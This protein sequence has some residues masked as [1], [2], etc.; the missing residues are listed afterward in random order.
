VTC[1]K[2]LRRGDVISGMIRPL[3][4]LEIS[5]LEIL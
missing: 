1:G 2:A 4:I 3:F 5:I